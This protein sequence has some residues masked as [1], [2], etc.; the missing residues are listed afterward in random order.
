MRLGAIAA[1]ETTLPKY[2]E[3]QFLKVSQVLRQ[4]L[5]LP[6]IWRC[7]RQLQLELL[8]V[9]VQQRLPSPRSPPMI[10]SMRQILILCAQH[11][12]FFRLASWGRRPVQGQQLWHR[13]PNSRP[14]LRLVQG[15]ADQ[16][17]LP[18]PNCPNHR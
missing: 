10:H 13:I 18:Y 7:N 4:P 16:Q 14:I 9:P 12:R 6:L 3:Q 11:R 8:S 5:L 15:Q 1:Y 17:H 2:F